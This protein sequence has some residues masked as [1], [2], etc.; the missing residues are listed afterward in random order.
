MK[1]NKLYEKNY[2]I[3][4]LEPIIDKLI[5]ELMEL[6]VELSHYKLAKGDRNNMLSELIDVK[7]VLGNI[8]NSEYSTQEVREMEDKKIN[9]F[10]CFLDDIRSSLDT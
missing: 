10:K 7:L 9:K 8:L 3:H 5:E 4:G 6:G 2:K 1:I